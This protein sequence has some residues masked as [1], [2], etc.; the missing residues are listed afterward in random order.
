M[1]K[2]DAQGMLETEKQGKDASHPDSFR[3]QVDGEAFKIN[4]RTPT[5]NLLL[6]KVGK[7]SCAFELVARYANGEEEVIE[8]DE[9][10][11]LNRHGLKD[12][13][14]RQKEIVTISINNDPYPI[15][16]GDRTIAEI[17]AKVGQTTEG[18]DLYQEKDGPP[19]P[20]PANQVVAIAGCEI[21][22]SQTS[23]GGS[24]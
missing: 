8:P 5:G 4:T 19:M 22:H 21:F 16:R 3:T 11:E 24:S 14:T 1:T 13:I 7:R 12:F 15:Q 6:G 2:G 10:L 18:Y 20:L 17:L 9:T 23:S